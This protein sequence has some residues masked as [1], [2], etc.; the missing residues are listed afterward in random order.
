[1][2]LFVIV[3]LAFPCEG[4]KLRC[5]NIQGFELLLFMCTAC[6][7][8]LCPNL[9]L[10][11][12][13]RFTFILEMHSRKRVSSNSMSC[14]FGT[15]SLHI[16]SVSVTPNIFRVLLSRCWCT[17]HMMSSCDMI[18]DTRLILSPFRSVV[19]SKPF[20]WL[21]VKLCVNNHRTRLSFSS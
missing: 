21:S 13:I 12:L 20:N 14:S 15:Y 10:K 18:I 9:S 11:N 2:F 6:Q 1:M 7:K 16:S 3:I 19:Y 8:A 17:W 4:R 5:G